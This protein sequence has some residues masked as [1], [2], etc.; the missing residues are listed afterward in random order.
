MKLV[1]AF[2]HRH[3]FID[4]DP[5]PAVGVRRAGAAVRA[6]TL[7][8]G[9][10]RRRVDLRRRRRVSPIAEVDRAQPRC[11]RCARR[12]R[13]RTAMTPEEVDLRA[14]AGAGRPVVERRH[15][16]VR[17]GRVRV[18][19]GGRRPGQ[20]RPP[21]QRLE[22]RCRMVGEGG[23]LG[24]TQRGRVEYALQGGLIY[25]DAIDNSAGVDC[26]DHEVNI[27]ILLD[28]I[29]AAGELTTKQRNELLAS[30]TDEVADLVLAHNKAQTLALMMAR[31]QSLGDGERARPLHR[32]VGGRG[33]ARPAARV[34]SV[35]PPDRRTAARQ[36]RP[37]RARVR[38]ADRVH[39]EHQR[40]RDGATATCPTTR[41]C[42]ATSPTT[43]R[44][45][46]ASATPRRSR[47]IRCAARSSP[48]SS[49]TRWSTCRGSP[50]TIA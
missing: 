27:K 24:F 15:R 21:R 11:P 7:L 41:C 48:R 18:E 46:S 9:R 25:T 47:P 35:R 45:R 3:V 38:R 49:S 44:R 37:H 30:M 43:S 6:A 34:P 42:V 2:D 14:P 17:E 33:L 39:E 32:D 29:V 36:Y 13:P 19:R 1:A 40:R 10:L 4:P 8:V 20:R 31:K 22:L 26:S 12:S 50:S 16:H 28:G 23:N 5:D